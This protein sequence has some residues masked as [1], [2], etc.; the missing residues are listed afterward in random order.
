MTY[1]QKLKRWR[2]E[3]GGQGKWRVGKTRRKLWRKAM[4]KRYLDHV[5]QRGVGNFKAGL[6][7][8]G[9]RRLERVFFR[10][11]YDVHEVGYGVCDEHGFC[12]DGVVYSFYG[13]CW[14]RVGR[15]EQVTRIFPFTDRQIGKTYSW[16]E[17]LWRETTDN[18]HDILENMGI[19]AMYRELESLPV[20]KAFRDRIAGK[21]EMLRHHKNAMLE[22]KIM[23]NAAAKRSKKSSRRDLFALGVVV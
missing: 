11:N 13:R 15:F 3:H 6:R 2:R 9:S 14:R 18:A 19:Y 7:H 1:Q 22:A 16:L 12:E 17:N 20:P 4:L 10:Y 5:C 8:L 23:T 21:Y